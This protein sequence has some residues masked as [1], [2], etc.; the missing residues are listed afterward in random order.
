MLKIFLQ[1]LDGPSLL[2]GSRRAKFR[3]MA[4]LCYTLSLGYGRIKRAGIFG[5][6]SEFNLTLCVYI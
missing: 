4:V 2:A 5:I 6:V 1:V 3:F